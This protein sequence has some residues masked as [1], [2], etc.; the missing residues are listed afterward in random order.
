MDLWNF[1]ASA[2]EPSKDNLFIFQKGHKLYSLSI[3]VALFSVRSH[4]P[5][6]LLVGVN[7][8]VAQQRIGQLRAEG[9][10]DQ[11][12]A[13]LD[14]LYAVLKRLQQFAICDAITAT[15]GQPQRR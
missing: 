1:K 6:Q 11:T 12:D 3:W 9:K 2:K 15:W 13:E 5:D 8:Q 10:A 14:E 4:P 7:Q